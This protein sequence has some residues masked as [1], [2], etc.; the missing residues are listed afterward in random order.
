[1]YAQ[2]SSITS[3]SEGESGGSTTSSGT[4]SS[5]TTSSTTS[6]SSGAQSLGGGATSYF[7]PPNTSKAISVAG[8][9]TLTLLGL[10]IAAMELLRHSKTPEGS[11][12]L[13]DTA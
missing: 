7:P 9:E 13:E 1:M 6:I 2:N 8:P 10:G 4:T 12:D 11:K 5:S 3:T